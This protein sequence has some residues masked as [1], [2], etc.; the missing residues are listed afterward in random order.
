[1]DRVVVLGIGNVLIGD[2]GFGPYAVRVLQSRYDF[3]EAVE[4]LDAGT[5][6]L[7][8]LPYLDR[9]R[10][11]VVLDTISSDAPPGTVRVFRREQLLSTPMPP[12][13]NP[14]Q[15]GLREALLAAELTT[16][17][18]DEVVLI[19]VV[20]SSTVTGASLSAPVRAAVEPV[21]AA[22]LAELER[23]GVPAVPREVPGDPDIWWEHGAPA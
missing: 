17:T 21:L 20:P 15:P 13:L 22:T 8:F 19:G 14:H 23:L 18:P 2:D 7:D 1:V 11:L 10:A 4:V 3:S 9:T 6:G 12:R 5:P 16:G